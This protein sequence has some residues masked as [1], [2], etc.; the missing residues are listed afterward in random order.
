MIMK[1]FITAG[2]HNKASLQI[3]LYLKKE[4][5]F[6]VH[7]FLINSQFISNKYWAVKIISNFQCS[8]LLS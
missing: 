7:I 3:S 4:H 6:D 2:T 5:V 1:V 8:T